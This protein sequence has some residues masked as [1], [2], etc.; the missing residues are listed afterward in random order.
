MQKYG[1]DR[2]LS[3]FLKKWN[4]SENTIIKSNLYWQCGFTDR[5]G[6]HLFYL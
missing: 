6:Y 4:V 2:Q 3:V 5:E 1:G